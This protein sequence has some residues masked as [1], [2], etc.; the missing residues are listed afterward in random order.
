MGPLP[1]AEASAGCLALRLGLSLL[2]LA[3]AAVAALAWAAAFASALASLRASRSACTCPASVDWKN[4]VAFNG[5]GGARRRSGAAVLG[6]SA[7]RCT[8]GGASCAAGWSRA[9]VD[10][11]V[12]SDREHRGV[13]L[14]T[15]K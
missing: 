13:V 5:R 14:V 4:L 9:R 15:N 10:L 1:S 12:P 2:K 11:R 8:A 7:S 3:E 6:A